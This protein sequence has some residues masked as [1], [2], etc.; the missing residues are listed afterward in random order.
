MKK[1]ALKI[2]ATLLLFAAGAKAQ[3]SDLG[4]WM[5]YFGNKK[6]CGKV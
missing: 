3:E 1:Q 5:I 6:L 4:N 2:L